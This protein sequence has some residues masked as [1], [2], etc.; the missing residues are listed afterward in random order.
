MIAVIGGGWAG[1]AAAVELARRGC[2]VD[3]VRGGAGARRPRARASIRDGL[4]LDN[5]QHLLLGAY[6]ET[7]ALAGDRCTSERIARG[8]RA[9][10]RSGRS[11]RP[12]PTRCRCAHATCPRRSGCSPALLGARGLSWRE[13]IATIRWFARQRAGGFRC[14]TDATVADLLPD[15]PA[16]VRDGSVG[17]AVPRRAQH[18]AAARVGAG[19]PERAARIVRRRGRRG[20][21]GVAAQRSRRGDSRA[22]RALADA[23]EAMPCE[24]RRGRGSRTS[25]DG[26]RAR[27]CGG[28]CRADAAIVAVGPHQLAAAFDPALARARRRASRPRCATSQRFAW[29]PITPSISA[30]A[31][32]LRCRAG[33][34]RLDDSPGQWV[35]D[36][37]RHPR[38]RAVVVDDAGHA[39]AAIGRD[40]R[41][42][43]ARR[44]RPS[45]ARGADRSRNCVGCDRR[46]RRSCWS[47]VIAE[48]R[49]TYACVPRLA[50]SGVRP[51]V[52]AASISRAITRTGVSR[53]ARG[54]GAQRRCSR[55]RASSPT[56]RHEPPAAHRCIATAI[57]SGLQPRASTACC[58]R[59]AAAAA[60]G[61]TRAP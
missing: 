55:A 21:D 29:E 44:A 54:R 8:S 46:C 17:A 33:L 12:A 9:A 14:A 26:V 57:A 43:R 59:A 41:T 51:A 10:A 2:R 53:D 42:R 27:R 20:G 16:R 49:A 36:R 25:T 32:P 39:R 37:A 18:A 7:L 31:R 34:V 24:R 6:A 45:G 28:R 30:T 52:R 48:K 50:R 60:R 47:Q 40:Q 13:R 1:C 58:G 35:F 22:R 3:A 56:C 38:A 5:G 19:V 23:R 11:R 15:L 61:S 4:P